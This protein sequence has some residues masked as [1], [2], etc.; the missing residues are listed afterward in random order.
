MGMQILISIS[1]SG[2]LDGRCHR[3]AESPYSI[4][5]APGF[6]WVGEGL[7]SSFI[8]LNT[9][10]KG[11]VLGTG[12]SVCIP[13]SG[14]SACSRMAVPSCRAA[15]EGSNERWRTSVHSRKDCRLAAKWLWDAC[16]WATLLLRHTVITGVKSYVPDLQ[17]SCANERVGCVC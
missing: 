13:F 11:R 10:R 4:T 15:P 9:P 2:L 12:S 3:I 17:L 7:H 14:T 6:V 1:I 16:V 5:A 8:G